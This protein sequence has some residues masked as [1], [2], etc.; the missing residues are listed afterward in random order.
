MARRFVEAFNSQDLDAF[1]ATLH[2]EVEIQ[3]L[4]G[5]RRG[6]A[7]ARAWG[8]RHPSG[9][10]EQHLEVEDAVEH[11]N[12]V[13]LLARRQWRWREGGDPAEDEVM[14]VLVTFRDGLVARWQP[15]AE[16]ADALAAAGIR[17]EPG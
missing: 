5:V 11:H 6:I 15:Y 17:D 12:H 8:T 3:S 4:K 2:P 14:G 9:D 7:E 13:V 10:L 16:R 1:V